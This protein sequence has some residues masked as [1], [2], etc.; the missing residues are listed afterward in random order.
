MTEE[1]PKQRRK[2]RTWGKFNFSQ[3]F[4]Q[5]PWRSQTQLIGLFFIA[6]VVVLLV[7][8]VYLTSAAA[9]QAG[10][11]ALSLDHQTHNLERTIADRKP[12]WH[13]S[14]SA[15]IMQQRAEIWFRRG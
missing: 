5:A 3:A 10:L 1:R 9:S 11:T 8:A 12:I 13:Y 7:A 2:G 4:K 15:S 14:T 6:L